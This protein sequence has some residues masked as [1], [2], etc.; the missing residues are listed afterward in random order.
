MTRKP[1]SNFVKDRELFDLVRSATG[2]VLT[3][4]EVDELLAAGVDRDRLCGSLH[5]YRKGG[6]AAAVVDEALRPILAKRQASDA[7]SSRSGDAGAAWGEKL[8]I[9]RRN[10][11]LVVESSETSAGEPTLS[12]DA[13]VSA[14]RD[15]RGYAWD[16]KLVFQL[17]AGELPIFACVVLGLLTSAEFKNHGAAHDKAMSVEHQ[18][19]NLFIKVQQRNRPLCAVPVDPAQAFE[20]SALACRRLAAANRLSVPAVVALLGRTTARMV[21]AEQS[22]GSAA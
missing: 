15:G 5:G 2:F 3:P 19:R 22:G 14:G 8:R 4:S 9:F 6:E 10:A 16:G 17:T 12:F 7:Q 13:A 21:A 1:Q 18:G 11:A 20:L